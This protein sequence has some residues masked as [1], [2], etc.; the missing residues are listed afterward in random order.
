M[1][2]ERTMTLLLAALILTAF[3]VLAGRYGAEDRPHMKRIDVSPARP[4]T[5]EWLVRR[6]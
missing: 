3:F 5:G 6:A 4:D 1:Y 2:I